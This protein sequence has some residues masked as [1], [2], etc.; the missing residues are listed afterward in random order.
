[1]QTILAIAVIIL[2]IFLAVKL[3]GK[4]IKA[5]IMVI[6][7]GFIIYLITGTNVINDILSY[8]G[9]SKNVSGIINSIQNTVQV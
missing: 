7:V 4:L 2:L 3:S 6:F 5:I 8:I 9:I 1:M